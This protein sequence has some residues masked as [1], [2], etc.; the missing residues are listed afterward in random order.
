MSIALKMHSLNW[1]LFLKNLIR[2]KVF[3]AVMSYIKIREPANLHSEPQKLR[4]Q[5]SFEA[6]ATT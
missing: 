5:N 4:L 3:S 6:I 2:E 1:T